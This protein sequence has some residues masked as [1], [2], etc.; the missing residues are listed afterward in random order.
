LHLPDLVRD[1]PVFRETRLAVLGNTMQFMLEPDRMRPNGRPY[2]PYSVQ[3][4]L[5][6]FR[7]KSLA[8]IERISCF[9]GQLSPRL[10]PQSAGRMMLNVRCI[11]RGT[12]SGFR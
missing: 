12:G 8:V 7:I 6:G 3:A 9:D 2:N 11:H 4:V 1:G 10:R 5:D